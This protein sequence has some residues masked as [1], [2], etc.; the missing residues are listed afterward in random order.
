MT[1]RLLFDIAMLNRSY[2][3]GLFLEAKEHRD[4]TQQ[5]NNAY[6]TYNDTG[7]H[8]IPYHNHAHAKTQNQS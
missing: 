6:G 3:T 4:K 7:N 8:E 5:H 2:K 1:E